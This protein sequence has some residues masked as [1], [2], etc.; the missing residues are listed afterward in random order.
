MMA[1]RCAAYTEAPLVGSGCE[2]TPQ[3][4][5]PQKELFSYSS[6]GGRA[7]DDT[8]PTPRCPAHQLGLSS[9]DDSC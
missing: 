8:A 5:T 4:W 9:T 7:D 1:S 6:H 2:I 3:W